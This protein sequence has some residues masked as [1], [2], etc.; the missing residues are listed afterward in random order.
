MKGRPTSRLSG[1]ADLFRTP[2]P[3]STQEF[4][5]TPHS[6]YSDIPETPDGPGEM[7]VSPISSVKK[8]SATPK[9]GGVKNLFNQIKRRSEAKLGGVKQLLTTPKQKSPA[10]PS[11]VK[12]MFMVICFLL[13]T[14]LIY[15][16]LLN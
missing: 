6:L 2:S 10:S 7:M 15:F 13:N 14:E 11:G 3:A 5:E 4:S 16:E 12:E 9:L 1:V 8:K